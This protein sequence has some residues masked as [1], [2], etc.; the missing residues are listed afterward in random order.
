MIYS[1]VRLLNDEGKHISFIDEKRAKWYLDRN[2][3]VITSEDPYEV[4]LT[5]EAA[6]PNRRDDEFYL[7]PRQNMCVICGTSEKLTRH[8]VIPQSYR[9]HFRKELKARSSHDVL[10]VCRPCHD[11]YNIFE[12][13]RNK[14]LAK[15]FGIS[16]T[17]TSFSA[18]QQDRKVASAAK[19]L[20]FKSGSIPVKREDELLELVIEYLQDWPSDEDLIRLGKLWP[21]GISDGYVTLG[22][23]I[24][25]HSTE[26]ELNR[27][28]KEWRQ[29]FVDKMSP[30]FL[31]EGWDVNRPLGESIFQEEENEEDI[32]EEDINS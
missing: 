25:Q 31:P 3:A 30:K 29:H 11:A 19:A 28:A 12:V 10:A 13:E 32:A 1:N 24:V 23:F 9:R 6:T 2:L 15:E 7:V 8:H 16:H 5:F 20:R 14:G 18:S 22:K 21:P 17:G 4:M 26:E 27:L